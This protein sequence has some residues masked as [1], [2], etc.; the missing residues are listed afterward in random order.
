MAN[1]RNISFTIPKLLIDQIEFRSKIHGRSRNAEF[2]YLLSLALSASPEAD[3]NIQISDMDPVNR[4]ARIDF[5]TERKILHR[6]DVFERPLGP[7]IVRLV[8][9]GIQIKVDHE[10]ALIAAVMKRQGQVAA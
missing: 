3:V 6:C 7:E 2:R 4:V 10:L 9:Y 5:K 1:S 8:A